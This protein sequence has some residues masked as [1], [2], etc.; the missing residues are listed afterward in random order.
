LHDAHHRLTPNEAAIL[1]RSLE[2]FDLFWL[3]DCTPAEN[4]DALRRVRSQTLTPLA[5]GE[6]FNSVLDFKTLISEQLIDYVRAAVTHG[7]G[8]T[9]MKKL[10]DFAA[11]YQ[12]KSGFHGPTDISPVGQA[13]ALHL[14]IAIHNFGIQEYMQHSAETL[15]VFRTSYTF[16]D[17]FLHPGKQ[18]GLG[19]EYDEG[20]GAKYPYCPAYLPVSRLQTDGTM[21]DW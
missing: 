1:G 9:A 19:V 2:P 11:L 17:G 3:E 12:I 16:R 13:A 6:V 21:H 5:I 14:D 10:M 20:A 8:I 18:P 15:G 7:G 4:Q